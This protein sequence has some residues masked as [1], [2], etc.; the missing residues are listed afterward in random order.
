M[1]I[2]HVTPHLPPD[3][4]ANALLPFHLGNWASLVGDEVT[5]VAHE[6]RQAGADSAAVPLA[7]PVTWLTPP[8]RPVRGL[9]LLASVAAARRII[10]AARPVL[11][12]ADVVHI[13]SNGLLAELCAWVAAREGKPSV[14]TLY[15]TEIWHYRARRWPDLFTRAYRS[16][17]LVTFYSHG[18]MERAKE[19]GLDR[20]GLRVN[21]PAV[22]DEFRGV[23]AEAR[24]AARTAL[25]FG[26]ESVLV[27]V[28]RLHPLAGQRY[29]IEAMPEIVRRV[30][31]TR[32]MIC[33]TGSLARD[34]QSLSSSL[35]VADQVIFTGLLDN[36]TVA[37]YDTAADLFVLPS[38][39][40]ACPTVALEALA[41]GTPVVSSDNPGGVELRRV[42]GDDV[43]VV[44]RE[45]PAALAD[46]VVAML[47]TR[48]RTTAATAA[49]IER[50]LRPIPVA[51]GFRSLYE[52][53]RAMRARATSGSA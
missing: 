29:L 48:R 20:E 41:C 4:G 11:R 31:G 50:E 5:Y 33:G 19:L 9:G 47:R 35:G 42:F 44:P 14:L 43:V 7:G 24:A 38:L 27:N 39:L 25:G 30:P 28:K 22:T 2:C 18:L 6:R 37:G 32:L 17:T 10:R 3:Q 53:A 26:D 45:N 12:A 52:E 21:Y 23:G 34:L 13:H 36:K 49:I 15:G 16:A 46:A 51:A 1:R 40:E 8:G